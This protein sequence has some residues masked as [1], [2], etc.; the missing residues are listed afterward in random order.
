MKVAKEAVS[1]L[2]K[3]M[4]AAVEAESV[5]VG[6]QTLTVYF[7]D[8]VTLSFTQTERQDFYGLTFEALGRDFSVINNL[9]LLVTS[10]NDEGDE[11]G[12]IVE[13]GELVA[14]LEDFLRWRTRTLE[15]FG[16]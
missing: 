11:V 4:R 16:A 12:L 13:D 2:V 5:E 1:G 6:P 10:E 3:A 14:L 9:E 8:D 7:L 15:V